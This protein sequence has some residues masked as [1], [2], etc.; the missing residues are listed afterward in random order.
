MIFGRNE[1]GYFHPQN[2]D[3]RFYGQVLEQIRT[4]RMLHFEFTAR[5][6]PSA[7]CVQLRKLNY[8]VGCCHGSFVD[9]ISFSSKVNK[10]SFEFWLVSYKLQPSGH[11][12]TLLA[13]TSADEEGLFWEENLM[14][15]VEMWPPP[16]HSIRFFGVL[17]HLFQALNGKLIKIRWNE[18]RMESRQKIE[19]KEFW[20]VE[21]LNVDPNR[22]LSSSE[23]INSLLFW[24]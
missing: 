6:P 18:K 5:Y 20:G 1:R 12:L 7:L 9:Q 24:I 19:G 2:K 8:I 23:S 15:E 22:V 13:R 11:V 10:S 17:E 4:R 21:F 14:D 16:V 3:F